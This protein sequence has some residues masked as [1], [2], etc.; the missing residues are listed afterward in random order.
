MSAPTILSEHVH[1]VVGRKTVDVTFRMTSAYAA[2][3]GACNARYL[4]DDAV[5]GPVAP[6]SFLVVLE[7]PLLLQQPYISMLGV[8]EERY[9]GYLLHAFQDTHYRRPIRP[10]D[11]LH[12]VAS[13]AEIRTTPAGALVVCKVCTTQADSG[14]AVATSWIGSLL[15]GCPVDTDRAVGDVA[16]EL[17]PEEVPTAGA[18]TRPLPISRAFPFVYTECSGHFNPIHTQRSF[19]RAAGFDDLVV[20]GTGTW[21]LASQN[22]IDIYADGDPGRLVRFGARFTGLVAPDDRLTLC[23][24]PVS[25]RRVVFCV[26]D[27]GKPAA[28][29][30]G[31]AEFKS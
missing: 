27:D 21:A 24:A 16:P 7:W 3:I 18:A 1:A 15:R 19:A 2:A 11:R 22:L 9:F 28:M 17:G 23:H 31:I 8:E 4:D 10:G 29:R 5:G 25:D 14:E 6:P 30:R 26:N 20:H 13:I 12:I